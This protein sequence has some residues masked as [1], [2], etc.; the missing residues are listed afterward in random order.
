MQLAH[1]SNPLAT[2]LQTLT[3]GARVGR[4]SFGKADV[5]CAPLLPLAPREG[6]RTFPGGMQFSTAAADT[7]GDPC[8]A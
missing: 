4:S 3:R 8:P 7:K 1:R 5:P 6:I 2:A